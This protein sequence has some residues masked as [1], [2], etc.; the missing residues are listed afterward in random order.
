MDKPSGQQNKIKDQAERNKGGRPTKRKEI[1]QKISE[2]RNVGFE[3]DEK[4]ARLRVAAS[5]GCPPVEQYHYAVISKTTYYEW[6]KENP[7]LADELDTLEKAALSIKARRNMAERIENKD[8]NVS[9]EYLRRTDNKMRTQKIEHSGEVTRQ[10]VHA[11]NI[12]G[13]DELRREYERKMFKLSAKALQE[14][15]TEELPETAQQED[16]IEKDDVGI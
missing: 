10:S 8:I 11:F 1:N 16:K 4:I 3:K 6:C 12:P 5:I 9:M 7:E 14:P 15:K 2:G 13:A